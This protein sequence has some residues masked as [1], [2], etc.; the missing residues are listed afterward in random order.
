MVNL[1]RIKTC[2]SQAIEIAGPLW[3]AAY[4]VAVGST[5][6]YNTP[7]RSYLLQLREKLL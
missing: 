1:F 5:Y 6:L 2:L 7:T 3:K 4:D